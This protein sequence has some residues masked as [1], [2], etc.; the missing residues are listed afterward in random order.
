MSRINLLN[1]DDVP[2]A[3]R[4]VLDAVTK[5]LGFIPN[6]FRLMSASPAVLTGFV[7]LQKALSTTL[8]LATRDAI[9]L[10]VSEVN[11]CYHCVAA[12]SYMAVRLDQASTGEI[13]PDRHEPSNDTQVGAAARFAAKVV[14]THGHIGNTDMADVRDAGFEDRQILEIVALAIQ[15]SMA[16][17][18]NNVAGTEIDFP[19]FEPVA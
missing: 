12:R 13:A 9:A 3:S 7:D 2:E 17:L 6:V 10:V 18:M 4:P 1:R 19:L 8:D 16:N 5:K 15:F 14:E 11:G